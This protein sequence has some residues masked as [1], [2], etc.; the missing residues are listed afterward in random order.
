MTRRL[1]ILV[2]YDGSGFHGWQRQPGVR[3]VQGELERALAVVA[4]RPVEVRGAS[5]T[6]AGVHALGQVAAFS[7]EGCDGLDPRRLQGGVNALAGGDVVVR[8]IEETRAD[9]D[10]RANVLRKTY[11]YR[12]FNDPVPS[13]LRAGSHLHVGAPLDREAMRAAAALLE[14]THDFSAF[15]ASDCTDPNVVRALLACR[16]IGDG[17]ELVVEAVAKGFLKNMVR[18]IAGTLVEAGKGRLAP[19]AIP[20]IVASRDR[21]RAGPTAPPHGLVLVGIEYEGDDSALVRIAEARDVDGKQTIKHSDAW[22]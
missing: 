7:L 9:F 13:P 8:R 2:E 10:P 21:G 6:D 15:R 16:V 18:I 12:I 19:A 22:K 20:G 17:E 11:R 14:G 1:R 3:T 4:R 5:R